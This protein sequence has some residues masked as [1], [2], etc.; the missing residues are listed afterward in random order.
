LKHLQNPLFKRSNSTH[1]N[2]TNN[3]YKDQRISSDEKKIISKSFSKSKTQTIS[4][5]KPNSSDIKYKSLLFRSHYF[6]FSKN[7]RGLSKFKV[8]VLEHSGKILT[9]LGNLEELKL[10]ASEKIFYVAKDGQ[11][12]N[13]DLKRFKDS[14]IPVS[15][16]FISYCIQK[17]I[18]IKDPTEDKIIHLLPFP[19]ATPIPNL[20]KLS[21]NVKGFNFD[22]NDDLEQVALILGFKVV[23]EED[24]ADILV[25]SSQKYK[26]QVNANPGKS[27]TLLKQE[28]WLLKILAEGKLSSDIEELIQ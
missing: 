23:E 21:L 16:R 10:G 20:Q 18:I 22:K 4:L 24:E 7:V 1:A 19:I 12:S 17:Q 8:D 3:P 9:D 26:N 28:K 6:Y 5:R 15:T 14:L 13:Q 27:Q 2:Q 25:L 11:D